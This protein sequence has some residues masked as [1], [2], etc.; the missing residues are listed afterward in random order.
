MNSI[1]VPTQ[2]IYREARLGLRMNPQ[3]HLRHI[4]RRSAL[5]SEDNELLAVAKD[6]GTSQEGSHKRTNLARQIRLLI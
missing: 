1:I 5:Y 2:H 6:I 4:S 3:I